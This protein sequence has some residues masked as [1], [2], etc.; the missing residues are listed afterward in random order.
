M[1]PASW[2]T[3]NHAPNSA[4][5]EVRTGLRGVLIDS[6]LVGLLCFPRQFCILLCIAGGYLHK[7]N[8][9]VL[10]DKWVWQAHLRTRTICLRTWELDEG[11]WS[12]EK[13]DAHYLIRAGSRP[14]PP[15]AGPSD[16][17]NKRANALAIRRYSRYGG[18]LFWVEKDW[19]FSFG[20]ATR[21][22]V[23]G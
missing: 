20:I 8:A 18:T 21:E 14:L 9:Y 2:G 22:E 6:H 11:V 15:P 4:H 3:E 5:P 16:C 19:I 23:I 12:P 10:V 1:I 17:D 13:K 7:S